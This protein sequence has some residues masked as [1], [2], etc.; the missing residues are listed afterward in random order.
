MG[1]STKLGTTVDNDGGYCMLKRCGLIP[2]P[3]FLFCI[4]VVVVVEVVILYIALLGV[5]SKKFVRR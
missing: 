4:Q 1:L 3:Q 5:F 2:S